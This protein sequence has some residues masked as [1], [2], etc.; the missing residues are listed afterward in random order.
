MKILVSGN[1]GYIG[2]SVVRQLRKS[3]PG[4]HIIGFDIGYFAHCLTN[5]SHY[6]DIVI[7]QQVYGDIRNIPSEILDGV[8]I[9]VNLAAISNDPMSARFEE[10]TY[11]INYRSCV[12]LAK[13]ARERGVKSFV[14]A[15]SCSVYGLADDTPRKEGDK[16]N[17]LTAYAKSKIYAEEDLEKLAT[18]QFTVTCLRFATA[19]GWTNRFRLDL[20]LNDFVAGALIN[21][22]ISILSDGSPWRPM[23]NTKDMARAIDWA[24]QRSTSNGGKFI[25]VNAGSNEWNNQIL[26]LAEAVAVVIPD[27]SI[28]VNPDAPP[29]KRSYRANFDLF[30]SLAPHFQPQE[31]LLST[32]EEIK[33]NLI[34]MNF[35]DPNYRESYMIRLKVL[36]RHKQ[37]DLLDDQLQWKVKGQ[38]A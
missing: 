6:P 12:E 10:M 19:C 33:K 26:T 9:V 24:T 17:P 2:P 30:R 32:V 3:Y 25:T 37:L 5:A 21:K 34:E 18:D 22:S 36:D 7:D 4:A 35:S 20:V 14:F 29:D 31:D 38:S 28:T 23:I 1:L 13:L 27:I 8:D 11:D 16:L 15:S